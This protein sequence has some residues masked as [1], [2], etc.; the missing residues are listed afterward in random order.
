MRARDGDAGEREHNVLLRDDGEDLS[1]VGGRSHGERGDGAAVGD[2]EQHPAVEKGDQI[3]VSLAQINVLAA[4]VGK[5]RAEFGEG[6]A[7]EERN[8]AADHPHQQKQHGLRQ[9]AGNVFGGEKNR[10]ADDAADQ[11]QHGIEQAE[12]ANESR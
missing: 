6:D 7:A 12:S 8:H 11:Q 9:R 10:R 5:H 3:A 2:C 4:G 1:R